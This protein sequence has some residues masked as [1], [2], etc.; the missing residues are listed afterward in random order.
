MQNKNVEKSKRRQE[1]MKRKRNI[2]MSQIENLSL[3]GRYILNQTIWAIKY[4]WTK[5]SQV[6]H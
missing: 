5:Y 2:K 4:K 6:K 1:W 3:D